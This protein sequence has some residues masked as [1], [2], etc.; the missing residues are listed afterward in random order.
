MKVVIQRVLRAKVSGT[1][2]YKIWF[3]Y[4]T[5]FLIVTG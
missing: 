3:K 4:Q 2:T 5:F 1:F